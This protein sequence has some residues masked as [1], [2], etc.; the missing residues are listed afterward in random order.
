MRLKRPHIRGN[1]ADGLRERKRDGRD[2]L[3]AVQQRRE[4][5]LERSKRSR[6]ALGRDHP[7]MMDHDI[8]IL[9]TLAQAPFFSASGK[10]SCWPSIL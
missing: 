2:R 1:A 3:Q 5:H 6:Q 10:N 4:R 7:A 9:A 8:V